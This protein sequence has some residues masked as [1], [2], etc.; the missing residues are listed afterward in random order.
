MTAGPHNFSIKQYQLQKVLAWQDPTQPSAT[1]DTGSGDADE[2]R[3]TLTSRSNRARLLKHGCGLKLLVARESSHRTA[4][5]CGS[6]AVCWWRSLCL[7]QV[8]REVGSLLKGRA[9]SSRRGFC[10]LLMGGAVFA[11]GG[12]GGSHHAATPPTIP[13]STASAQTTLAPATSASSQPPKVARVEQSGRPTRVQVVRLASSLTSPSPAKRRAVI[14]PGI[15]PTN[16]GLT[17]SDH[18]TFVWSTLKTLPTGDVRVAA[19]VT[20]PRTE[21]TRWTV[22]LASVDGHWVVLGANR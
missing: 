18:V 17:S 8:G 15:D 4:R 16:I 6:A 2:V 13:P 7:Y 10:L 3:F 21:P 20:A 11:L 19:T 1:H 22:Y 14:A 5:P 9:P 12:C